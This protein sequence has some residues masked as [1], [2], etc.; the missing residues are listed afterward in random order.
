MF[1]THQ[2]RDRSRGAGAGV[3][4]ESSYGSSTLAVHHQPPAHSQYPSNTYP[5]QHA[6]LDSSTHSNHSNNSGHAQTYAPYPKW[7]PPTAP[8]PAVSMHYPPQQVQHH[9]QEHH[10]PHNNYAQEHQPHDHGDYEQDHYHHE[11]HDQDPSHT[12]LAHEVHH[13][14][15]YSSE[16]TELLPG[17]QGYEW[18]P[19]AALQ[20]FQAATVQPPVV[21]DSIPAV[22]HHQP[23]PEPEPEPE[24]NDE[25]HEHGDDSGFTS[26]LSWG[27]LEDPVDIAEFLLN[28]P[29]ICTV[30][31]SSGNTFLHAASDVGNISMVQFFLK[32][33]P[34]DSSTSLKTQN[35]Q[36]FEPIH[37]AAFGG[38][39]HVVGYV[40]FLFN[41]VYFIPF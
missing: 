19:P 7:T 16:S 4:P 5:Q 38:M 17:Q 33:F 37:M 34:E 22:V 26:F 18:K 1:P 2:R 9:E 21:N 23:E 25:Q 11:S 31:D 3:G 6:P 32:N 28:D 15:P 30:A 40:I 27:K 39:L 20:A 36:G 8:A 14:T 10:H 35:D 24:G 13:E 29:V 41:T 12:G